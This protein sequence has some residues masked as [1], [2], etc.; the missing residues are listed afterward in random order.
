MLNKKHR[1]PLSLVHLAL[2]SGFTLIELLV[3]IAIIALMVGL[4]LPNF[5]GSRERA[6]DSKRKQELRQMKT[7]LRLYY[8]DYQGYP[9]DS[10]GPLYNQIKGC[11]PSGAATCP[12]SGCGVDFSAGGTDGCVTT[13]MKKFPSEFG[14]RIYYYQ[15]SSGADFLLK[16]ALENVSD[17]DMATSRATCPGSGSK[18][19]GTSDFCVC[20]D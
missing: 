10:G 6:R 9:A 17:P 20:G 2:T 15:L 5:V 7:A 14:T 11:G 1:W 16:V 4:A 13:Y 18:T 8:N 12:Y 3:V 19:C